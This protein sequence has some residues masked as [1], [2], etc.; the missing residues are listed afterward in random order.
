MPVIE[1]SKT[2]H[3]KFHI[4][5]LNWNGAD[6]LDQCLESVF[7]NKASNYRVTVID[8]DSSNFPPSNIDSRVN[9]VQLDKNYGFSKGYNL[10]IDKSDIGDDEYIILLNYDATLDENFI[11]LISEAVNNRGPNHI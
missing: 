10:G 9:I 6:I 5:I 1:P 11:S 2:I 3:P 4:C 8:N 7:R